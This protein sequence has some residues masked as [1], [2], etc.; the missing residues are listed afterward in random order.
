MV[1]ETPQVSA[2]QTTDE[3]S[4]GGDLFIPVDPFT[5][6]VDADMCIES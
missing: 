1:A 6:H 4:T 3:L 2:A 5:L